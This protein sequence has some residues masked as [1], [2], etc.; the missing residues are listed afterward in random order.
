MTEKITEK[1]TGKISKVRADRKGFMLNNEWY[2]GFEPLSVNAKDDV[3]FEYLVNG[4]FRN[5]V[6]GTLKV[7]SSSPK[8]I[9][10]QTPNAN[11]PQEVWEAKD[12]RSCRQEAIKAAVQIMAMKDTQ[13]MAVM[14]ILDLVKQCAQDLEDWVY[15]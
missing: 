4:D 8:D 7:V 3:E 9:T 6:K 1:G 10:A 14:V 11:V 5:I 12:R 13:D 2:S 15:R